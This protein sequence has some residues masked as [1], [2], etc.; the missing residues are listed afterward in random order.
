[1]AQSVIDVTLKDTPVPAAVEA[2]WRQ[3]RLKV[4]LVPQQ[5]PARALDSVPFCESWD[6]LTIDNYHTLA[7]GAGKS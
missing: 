6:D 4:E 7:Q 1:L 5:G 2:I 3:S